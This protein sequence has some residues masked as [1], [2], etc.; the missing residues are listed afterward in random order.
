MTKNISYNGKPAE[1]LQ[2]ELVDLRGKLR[3][4]QL[5]KLKTGKAKGYRTTR[6]NIA[7][8]LTALKNA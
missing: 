5:E 2:K 6:K 3:N 1:E 7:R 4:E 8:V